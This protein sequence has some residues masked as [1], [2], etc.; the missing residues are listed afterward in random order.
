MVNQDQRNAY[1]LVAII[2]YDKDESEYTA[3]VLK[4][5]GKLSWWYTFT[6]EAVFRPKGGSSHI[7]QNLNAPH[8]LFYERI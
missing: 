4:R 7:L 2:D 5:N 6:N 8:M 3:H 1:R